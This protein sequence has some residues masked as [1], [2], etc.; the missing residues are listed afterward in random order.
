MI[1]LRTIGMITALASFC[2]CAYLIAFGALPWPA[3]VALLLASIGLFALSVR[4]SVTRIRRIVLC[5][6][7][8]AYVLCVTTALAVAF[9][10]GTPS[11]I[12]VLLLALLTVASLALLRVIYLATKRPRSSLRDYYRC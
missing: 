9:L 1:A 3:M 4:R 6:G 8:C 10:H 2:L 5:L 12:L 7:W 11:V